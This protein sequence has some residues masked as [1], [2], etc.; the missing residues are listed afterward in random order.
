[1]SLVLPDGC[2]LDL[3]DQFYEKNN[4]ASISRS[5]LDT[6]ADL[7]VLCRQDNDT[8]A[9][10]IIRPPELKIFFNLYLL[11]EESYRALVFSVL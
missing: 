1:M 5:A 2:V 7:S 6:C 3:I 8:V 9:T 10:K 11:D 4:D